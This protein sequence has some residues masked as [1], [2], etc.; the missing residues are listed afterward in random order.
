MKH[1]RTLISMAGIAAVAF[2]V[3]KMDLL[4]Q[5]SIAVAGDDDKHTDMPGDAKKK[6]KKKHSDMPGD[7]DH[8]HKH[9][10]MPSDAMGMEAEM[11]A[12]TKAATPGEN[13]LVLASMAGEWEGEWIMWM[14]P[15]TPPSKSV[16][17]IS[18]KW[19]LDGRYMKET[20]KAKG[21]MG[22]YAGHG[23]VG[24]NNLDGLYEMVWMDN[25]STAIHLS[26]GYYDATSKTMHFQGTYRNPATGNLVKSWSEY[27][28]SDPN[29]HVMIGYVP[30]PDGKPFKH[31][32]GVTSRLK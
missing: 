27:D 23:Y 3:G 28:M 5:T 21:D 26:S 6:T 19:I 12:W 30:G 17:K 16:G 7:A 2:L 8:P 20:V 31:F 4:P 14:A 24:Y 25:W 22:A 18:R 32:E 9:S 11:A 1:A 13:H 10:D 15:G 29:R